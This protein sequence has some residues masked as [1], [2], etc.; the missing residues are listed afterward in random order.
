MNI[1]QFKETFRNKESYKYKTF[2]VLSDC[3]WHCR[4]CDYQG[5]PSKQLAG[6]GGIQGLERGTKNRPG[7]VIKSEYRK[8]K[9]CG[10]TTRFDCWN[11]KYKNATATSSISNKL[12]NRILAY[13]GYIDSIEERKRS[14]HE[15]VIDHR[16]PLE[17]RGDIEENN[18]DNMSD[19]EIKAKFQLLKKDDSGNHNLLKSRA[20]ENCLKTGKRGFP[21]GIKYYYA[22]NELW[23][24]DCP[25][26]GEEAKRGCEGCGWYDINEWRAS[27]NEYLERKGKGGE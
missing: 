13:Y 16:L 17:R 8:C 20:C 2:E 15:L 10:K 18:P 27:L 7:L 5:I 22:G 9:R 25:Q 1:T 6:G 14:S 11:G 24:E 4:N 19:E 12:M 26:M 21:L 3:K 23:P